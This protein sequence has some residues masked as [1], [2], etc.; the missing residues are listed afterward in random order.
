MD[1]Q[2]GGNIRG[3]RLEQNTIRESILHTAFP[4]LRWRAAR[5][6][7]VFHLVVVAAHHHLQVLVILGIPLL[8]LLPLILPLHPHLP[9]VRRRKLRQRQLLEAREGG[10]RRQ[11]R[12]QLVIVEQRLLGVGIALSHGLCDEPHALGVNPARRSHLCR[13]HVDAVVQVAQ[14]E[15]KTLSRVVRH[16]RLDKLAAVDESR[17]DLLRVVVA[18]IQL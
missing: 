3:V 8:V 14:H 2:H 9:F 5:G 7:R 10:S 13:R 12:R 6:A 4:P 1:I 11:T 18:A 15:C 16:H 17:H